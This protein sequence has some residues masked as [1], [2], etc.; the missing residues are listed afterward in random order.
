[1]ELPRNRGF[2][3]GSNVGL[4]D[5]DDVDYVALLNNDTI[6]DR[7]WLRPLVDA[8]E[9]DAGL[10]AACSKMVF[11]PSFVALT[12]DAPTFRAQGDGRDLGVRITGLA[13]DGAEVWGSTQFADGCHVTNTRGTGDQELCWTD[14]HAEVRVPV[15]PGAPLPAA[16]EIELSAEKAKRVT[17][18][19][20]GE[21]LTVEVGP[22]PA[23]VTV[24]IVG[25]AFDVINNVGS[26]LVLGGYGGDRG[27]LEPDRG[28]Y[29][30][31][32]EVFA[33]CGG[34]VLLPA[35]YLREVGIFDER[36]FMYYE[37][38]DLAWRGRLAGWRYH[39]VPESLVRHEHAASSK[40]GSTLFTHYVERN[41]FLTLARNAPWSMLTEALRVFLRDTL[42]I[43]KHQVLA[44][45]RRR[46]RPDPD[47]VKRRLRAVLGV[48]QAA[49]RHVAHPSR[50]QRV[51]APE[52][53]AIVD[54]WAVPQ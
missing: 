33:W 20:G 10:G 41:R 7:N 11:A 19:A 29:A 13:V 47:L 22:D 2:A 9:A 36:Y 8:L 26:R 6:P 45:V 48:R 31:P 14:A 40:E 23:W 25:E 49:A 16:V 44:P 52:R 18:T 42:V 15:T 12:V 30:Q 43:F 3:G 46:G 54:R 17:L 4:R 21:P 50:A 5:L 24:P 28:Q 27:F 51:S 1:M 37:D 32:E 39:Y 38:T 34:A 53:Q 35:R